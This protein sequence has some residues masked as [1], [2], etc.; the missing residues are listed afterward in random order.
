MKSGNSWILRVGSAV[1]GEEPTIIRTGAKDE[2]AHALARSPAGNTAICGTAPSPVMALDTIDGRVWP[3]IGAPAELDYIAP[4][5]PQKQDHKFD[6]K[7]WDC[8]FGDDERLVAVGDVFGQ[9]EPNIN[10]P[11]PKR[12]RPLLLELD[13][14]AEPVWHV[15]G[16]GPGNISQARSPSWRSVALV[17]GDPKGDLA[18]ARVEAEAVGARLTAR[19]F[20][21]T[22]LLG[23]AADGPSVRAA[24]DWPAP[25]TARPCTSALDLLRLADAVTQSPNSAAKN[26]TEPAKMV[27]CATS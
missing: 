1:W 20:D 22:T 21:V 9:H 13:G 15:D 12:T 2:K 3:L 24:T 16:L 7:L 8:E 4:D 18:G 27:F 23:H 6:E 10:P 19:G 26:G 5:D 11:P 17:V 14:E 25:Q